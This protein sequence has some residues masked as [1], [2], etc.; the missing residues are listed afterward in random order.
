MYKRYSSE[1]GRNGV[2]F[3]NIQLKFSTKCG[4]GVKKLVYVDWP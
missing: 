4:D 1:L 3:Q 2:S